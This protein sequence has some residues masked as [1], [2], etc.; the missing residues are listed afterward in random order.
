MGE[1][2]TLSD[3][4]LQSDEKNQISKTDRRETQVRSRKAEIN[5]IP[6]SWKVVEVGEIADLSKG[7]RSPREYYCEPDE[8]GARPYIRIADF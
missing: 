2:T 4:D 5:Q 8:P 7:K 6:E 1:Q 3:F